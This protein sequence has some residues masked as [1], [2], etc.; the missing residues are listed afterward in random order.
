MEDFIYFTKPRCDSCAAPK[1]SES[2][3]SHLKNEH[4]E[5]FQQVK[6]MCFN[7]ALVFVRVLSLLVSLSSLY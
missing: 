5:E 1:S 2:I 3:Y 6:V 7:L 4:V